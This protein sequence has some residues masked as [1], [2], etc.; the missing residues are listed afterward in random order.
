MLLGTVAAYIYLL[1]Y[2]TYSLWRKFHCVKIPQGEANKS[3]NRWGS[4]GAKG[5]VVPPSVFNQLLKCL[6]QTHII[7]HHFAAYFHLRQYKELTPHTAV[8]PSG[9]KGSRYTG[10]KENKIFLIYSIRKFRKEQL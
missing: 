5:G 7:L 1:L 8:S 4:F 9:R 6:D 10:K 3:A 2:C